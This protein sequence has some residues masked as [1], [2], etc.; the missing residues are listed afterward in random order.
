MESIEELIYKETESRLKE[1]SSKN[2]QFPKQAD[3]S[4]AIKIVS[5]IV[6]CII[7]IV[8]CMMEVIV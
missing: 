1:M 3:K 6:V 2:Y 8:L 4:D 7:L 5:A